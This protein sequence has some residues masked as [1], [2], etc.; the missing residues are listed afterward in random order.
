MKIFPERKRMK[1]NLK[2]FKTNYEQFFKRFF[3][4]LMKLACLC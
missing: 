1:N 4:V 2:H 3:L